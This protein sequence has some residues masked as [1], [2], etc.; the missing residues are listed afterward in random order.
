VVLLKTLGPFAMLSRERHV[1]YVESIRSN[2]WSHDPTA[3]F[4][5]CEKYF[6]EL[7]SGATKIRFVE[8]G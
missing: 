7:R 6:N 5:R 8:E 4:W 2:I 1:S 3:L